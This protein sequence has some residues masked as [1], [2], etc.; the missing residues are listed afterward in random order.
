MASGQLPING[1]AAPQFHY[2]EEHH[3][4]YLAKSPNGRCGIGGFL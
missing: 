3:R 2:A 4:Q 1:V